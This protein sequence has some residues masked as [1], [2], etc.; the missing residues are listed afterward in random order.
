MVELLKQIEK[1]AA[2]ILEAEAV[3]L[4]ELKMVGSAGRPTLRL[5]IDC[6]SGVTL[7]QCCRVSRALSERLDLEDP[8]AHSYRLEVSS[9][10]VTRPL[11]TKSD[12]ERNLNRQVD[13]SVSMGEKEELISGTIVGISDT[14]LHLR[15]NHETVDVPISRIVNVRLRL[16]W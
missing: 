3:E 2:P 11:S 9:P 5:Y 6:S 1:L 14:E 4:V 12:F 7:D 8:V 10:G 15:C 13:V 16:P